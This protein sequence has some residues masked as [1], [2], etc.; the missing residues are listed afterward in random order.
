MLWN[1]VGMA[2]FLTPNEKRKILGFEPLQGGEVLNRP[3]PA[4]H[5]EVKKKNQKRCPQP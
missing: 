5:G 2:P 4:M 1:R 3:A